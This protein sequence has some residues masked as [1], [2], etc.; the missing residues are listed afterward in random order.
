LR[1]VPGRE[2]RVRGCSARLVE[3]LCTFFREIEVG[4]G[5]AFRGDWNRPC[6]CAVLD[7]HPVM[8]FHHRG[9]KGGEHAERAMNLV[10]YRDGSAWVVLDQQVAEG[11]P[12]RI[13]CAII[14]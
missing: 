2:K 13:R 5:H 11:R 3:R 10:A 14:E 12:G 6:E 9:K 7:V 4:G 8:G 1:E